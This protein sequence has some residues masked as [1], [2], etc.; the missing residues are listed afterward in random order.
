MD[1]G[2]WETFLFPYLQQITSGNARPLAADRPARPTDRV[3][4]WRRFYCET[5]APPDMYEN[6]WKG[7]IV[8][9]A[10]MLLL[11]VGLVP[12]LESGS[13]TFVVLQ[14]AAIH[15]VAAI[16]ILSSFLYFEWDPFTPFRE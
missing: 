9:S 3:P 14:L 16:L 7:L 6:L 5:E 1:E 11:L 4:E 15:L 8:G 2:F 12:Y 13:A 10:M